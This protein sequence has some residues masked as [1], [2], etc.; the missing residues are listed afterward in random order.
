[1]RPVWDIDKTFKFEEAD[2]KETLFQNRMKNIVQYKPKAKCRIVSAPRTPYMNLLFLLHEVPV[3][4]P[5]GDPVGD[6]LVGAG[7]HGCALGKVFSPCLLIIKFGGPG[8]FIKKKGTKTK[9]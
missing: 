3:F 9:N 6:L 2:Q 1:M 8:V 5:K 4:L 7:S